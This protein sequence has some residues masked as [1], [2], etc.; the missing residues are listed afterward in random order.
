MHA[1]FP[2]F[3]L[4][5]SSVVNLAK[6]NWF[7]AYR[8][9]M[10]GAAF[11]CLESWEA[12]DI[13]MWLQDCARSWASQSS[14]SPLVGPKRPQSMIT[15]LISWGWVSTSPLCLASCSLSCELCSTLLRRLSRCGRAAYHIFCRLALP[16]FRKNKISYVFSEIAIT[17]ECSVVF[18][19]VIWDLWTNKSGHVGPMAGNGEYDHPARERILS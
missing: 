11:A 4:L 7:Y 5:L 9:F 16:A 3:P 15:I 14:G 19:L 18:S 8:N 6:M 10:L 12:E 2:C 13:T 1:R 17:C